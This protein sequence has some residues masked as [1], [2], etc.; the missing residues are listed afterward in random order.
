MSVELEN[1][2]KDVYKEMNNRE[3]KIFDEI[4]KFRQETNDQYNNLNQ[5]ISQ[6]EKFNW[7]AIGGG[8]VISWIITNLGKYIF[9]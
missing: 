5:K 9:R 4:K 2:I 3:E 7:I 1:K 6:I 8:I